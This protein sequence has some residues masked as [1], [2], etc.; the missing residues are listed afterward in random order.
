ML[1]NI[2]VSIC[3]RKF[4]RIS[5]FGWATEVVSFE[6]WSGRWKAGSSRFSVS[7]KNNPVLSGPDKTG[8]VVN[9]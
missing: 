1:T 4:F 5:L 9:M 7:S 6:K 3:L 2:Q 8:F